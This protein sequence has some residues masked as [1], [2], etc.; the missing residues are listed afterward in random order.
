MLELVGVSISGATRERLN[1]VSFTVRP[2]EVLGLVGPSGS[3]KSTV[4]A[5]MAGTLPCE[6][7]R[8]ALDGREVSRQPARLRACAGLASEDPVGP[9]DPSVEAWLHLWARLDGLPRQGL[10]ERVSQAMTRFALSALASSPLA[11]LSRVERN[12]VRCA[13]LWVRQPRIYLVDAADDALDAAA[14]RALV[15]AV[16]TASGAG[17]SVVLAL[18]HEPLALACCDRIIALD[19][20]A[21]AFEASRADADFATRLSAGCRGAQA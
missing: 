15:G 2:G 11:Q 7:G 20:G 18:T 5:V 1:R 16:R 17:A 9:L 14:E 8:V 4:L 6:R 21:V 19:A 10:G 3:G 12:R 13:R